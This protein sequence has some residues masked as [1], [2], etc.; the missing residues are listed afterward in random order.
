MMQ[1]RIIAVG[2]AKEPFFRQGVEEYIKRLTGTA[3]VT[4]VELADEPT[5]AG[6][7]A[8]EK[9]KVLDVEGSRIMKTIHPGEYCILLDLAGTA[10]TSEVFA[11]KIEELTL[12]GTSRFAYVIGGSLGVSDDVR[13]RADLRLSLGPMTYPHQMVRLI[14]AEQ[15]Y[16]ACMIAKGAQYHK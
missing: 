7:S 2:R 16:R 12:A 5:P 4:I 3:K 11:G 1:V 14:I 6:A 10:M 8:A 15:L 13:R 9:A